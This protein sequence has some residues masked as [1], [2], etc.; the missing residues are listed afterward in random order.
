MFEKK[1]RERKKKPR[2]VGL[3]PKLHRPKP[4]PAPN[5]PTRLGSCLWAHPSGPQPF[6]P[7]PIRSPP[8][9]SFTQETPRRAPPRDSGT[10]PET[11]PRSPRWWSGLAGGW[12]RVEMSQG[13]LR[14]GGIEGKLRRGVLALSGKKKTW[15]KSSKLSMRN[16]F[17]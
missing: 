14:R 5:T 2:N 6:G 9:P 4:H 11:P 7:P 1:G 12:V 8:F 15:P 3:H 13:G 17:G 16:F 10:P